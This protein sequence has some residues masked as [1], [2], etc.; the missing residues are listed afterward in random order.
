MKLEIFQWL[1]INISGHDQI[2]E[3]KRVGDDLV[4]RFLDREGG[5]VKQ[6]LLVIRSINLS[7]SA[8]VL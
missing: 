3:Q 2:R 1:E 5:V 8:S 4:I 6:V 7:G